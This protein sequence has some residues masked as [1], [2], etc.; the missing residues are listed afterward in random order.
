MLLVQAV[1]YSQSQQYYTGGNNIIITLEGT[2][3]RYEYRSEEMLVRYN[4]D[5]HKLEC[6]LPIDNLRPANDYS[7]ASML[8]DLFYTAKF[9]EL[10]IE[11]DAPVEKINA[12]NLYA[13]VL[14][15]KIRVLLQ[16]KIKEMNNQVTFTPDKRAL[17]F[18]TSFEL[19]FNNLNILVPA[20]YIPM[21]T[22][23]ILVTISNARWADT[24]LR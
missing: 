9:P 16:G 12:G 20:K 3:N 13:E 15:K 4:D 8:H 24:D 18:S 22:G 10:Q 7:P 1:A 6:V 11:I 21:L 14:N 23:R 5:T 17:M 2:D 19:T